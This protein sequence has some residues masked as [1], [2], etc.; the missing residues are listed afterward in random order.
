MPSLNEIGKVEAVDSKQYFP[1]MNAEERIVHFALGL[2]GETG[3]A[4]DVIKK[5]HRGSINMETMRAKL[6]E[7]LPDILIYLTALA[8]FTKIDLE[9]AYARKKAYNNKRFDPTAI[10]NSVT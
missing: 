3:E 1:F 7:E 10:T 4:V 2:A 8:T 6:E 9:E 5:W